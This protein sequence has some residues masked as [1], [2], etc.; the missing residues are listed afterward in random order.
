MGT[1]NKK[2]TNNTFWKWC[3]E[4]RALLHYWWGCTLV[5][6]LWRMVWEFP[7]KLKIELSYDPTIPLLDVYLD[8]TIIQKDTCTSVFYHS[9][10]H[11][12]QDLEATWMS[13]D[14]G[15]DKE[16]VVHIYNE[17]LRS[18]KKEQNNT[19]CSDVDEPKHYH[20]EWSQTQK[21]IWYHSHVESN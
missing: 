10:I 15:M 8:K 12:C 16:S 7:K 1:T 13:T 3:G 6:P 17:I 19:I 20:T 2:S 18:R 11:N 21:K 4:K 5:Q 14:R 9:T